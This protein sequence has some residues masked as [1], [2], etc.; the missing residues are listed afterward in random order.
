MK[1]W[2]FAVSAAAITACGLA[3]LAADAGMDGG[4][5]DP[6]NGID[7][8]S[9]GVTDDFLDPDCPNDVCVAGKCAELCQGAEL[10]CPAGQ[11]CEEVEGHKVCVPNVC[12]P[13][14]EDA[15]PCADNPYWCDDGFVPPC[16]C[17]PVPGKCVDACYGVTCDTD[18]VCVPKD[19]G[20]CHS[21]ADGCYVS[22][23]PDGQICIDDACAEDPCAGVTCTGGQYCNAD[24]DCVDPCVNDDCPEGCYEG[25]C[26]Y[27]KCAGVACGPGLSCEPATGECVK[28]DCWGVVCEFYEICAAGKC[29]DDPCWNVDCPNGLRCLGGACYEFQSDD[30]PDCD[31]D[32]GTDP[33]DGG[34]TDSDTD[35]DAGTDA[36]ADAGQGAAGGGSGC[37]CSAPGT[38]TGF[39]LAALL[40]AVLT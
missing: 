33:G 9:D 38:R 1:I 16:T 29:V 32:C 2:A 30:G 23:C 26:V 39:G 20:K 15:L 19:N 7:D 11:V 14:S 22:G 4:V 35:V 36:G 27:D 24:G 37:G 40:I 6:C 3:A 28:G 21:E 12:D 5:A 8:D 34:D 18:Y 25:K 31:T 10:S 13:E 17:E